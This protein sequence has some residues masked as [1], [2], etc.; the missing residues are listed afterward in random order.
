MNPRATSTLRRGRVEYLDSFRGLA[1]L[2]V[3]FHHT[4][5]SVSLGGAPLLGYHGVHLFFVLSGY[6][7]AGKFIP[8]LMGMETASS[9]GSFVMRRLRRIYPP[10]LIC[11]A[12][13]VAL[14]FASHTNVP[15]LQNILLR[16]G[17]VFNYSDY[18]DYFAINPG[19]WSLAVEMQFYLLLPWAAWL[20][21]RAL[22]A[23]KARALSFGLLFVGVGILSRGFGRAHFMQHFDAHA[24]AQVRFKWVTSHLDLFGVGILLRVL[25]EGL[26]PRG[27]HL[28]RGSAAMGLIFGTALLAVESLWTQRCGEWQSSSDLC[29]TV[30]GPTL[31]CVG[32]AILLGSCRAIHRSKE[33]RAFTWAGLVGV[34]QISYSALF[35]SPGSALC[36][37]PP[38]QAGVLGTFVDCDDMDHRVLLFAGDDFRGVARLSVDREAVPSS[39]KG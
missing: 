39:E 10:H 22:G 34:G 7:L 27:F 33:S 25:E 24:V 13:F 35:V 23:G 21:M 32:F 36:L 20:L 6:L 28:T 29:F 19:F 16:A 31:A 37:Q 9:T 8:A 30:L 38:L 26:L 15:D 18:Y 4:G 1:C 14:R 17:L 5:A 11:L 12:V 2:M 3:Y